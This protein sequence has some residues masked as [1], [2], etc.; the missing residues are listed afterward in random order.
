MQ[1]TLLLKKDFAVGE[2]ITHVIPIP[3]WADE[4]AVVLE[5][6]TGTAN[7]SAK[8]YT[9]ARFLSSYIAYTNGYVLGSS[10]G[11]ASYR[12]SHIHIKGSRNI[13]IQIEND[14]VAGA[15]WK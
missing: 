13:I 7:V 11:T 14:I 3:K 6:A 12:S 2:T 1:C 10:I 8:V 5:E 15:T 9:E 4:F